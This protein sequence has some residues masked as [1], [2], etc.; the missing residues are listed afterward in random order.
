M[1][2][3]W[4]VDEIPKAAGGWLRLQSAYDLSQEPNRMGQWP[5]ELSQC[6]GSW[7]SRSL[8]GLGKLCEFPTTT[9][10]ALLPT[11]LFPERDQGAPVGRLGLLAPLAPLG[12]RHYVDI[13]RVSAR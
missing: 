11:V 7:K 9:T 1:S 3:L 8:C 4:Y 5:T 10:T 2:K 13:S 12:V 6:E